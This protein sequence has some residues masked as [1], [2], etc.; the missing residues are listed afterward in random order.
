MKQKVEKASRRRVFG[1]PREQHHLLFDRRIQGVGQ[2]PGRTLSS[3]QL[4][5]RYQPKLGAAAGY[6][7]KS[8][9]DAFAPYQAALKTDGIPATA[10]QSADIQAEYERKVRERE[11]RE[12]KNK[13]PEPK[14]PE[15]TL[16]S[17]RSIVLPSLRI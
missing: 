15:A 1:R 11:Q 16:R 10:F 7:L 12:G 8:L 3:C 2:E 13:G 14:A 6:E 4:G 9:I 5:S 17:S